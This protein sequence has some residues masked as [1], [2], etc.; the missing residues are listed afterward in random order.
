M[1]TTTSLFATFLA[2]AC[3]ACFGSESMEF[4]PGLAPLEE[5]T[6]P[7]PAPV[8]GDAT[9]EVVTTFKGDEGDYGFA[10]ARGYIHAPITAVFAALQQPGTVVD[11]RRVNSFEVT[12][13]VET[14]YDVSFRIHNV[15]N[16]VVTVE[17]DTTWRQGVAQG[18]AE[19]PEVVLGRALKTDG[20]AFIDLLEDSVVLT[21]VADDRTRVEI[22]RH[23]ASI[24]GTEE[25]MNDAEVFVRDF[26]GSLREV[27]HGR[28]L[29]TY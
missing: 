27:A 1:K 29:P 19:A 6:A 9:P 18:T 10:H 23:R 5:S 7:E 14:G 17:F 4:P 8:D 16:E 25:D 21:K 24:K 15:V 11:R 3:A 2:L 20:T 22:V 12:P 28:P 13:N 26:Y